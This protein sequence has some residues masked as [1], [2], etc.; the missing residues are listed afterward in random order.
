MIYLI[1]F[2]SEENYVYLEENNQKSFIKPQNYENTKSKK[3]KN[4]TGKRENQNLDIF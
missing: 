2:L 3:F 4:N 1:L